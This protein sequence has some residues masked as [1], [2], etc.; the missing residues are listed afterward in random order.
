[1]N[2]DPAHVV[3]LTLDIV[4]EIHDKSI[5]RFGVSSGIRDLPLLESAVAAPQATFDGASPFEDLIE[6][7]AAYLFY[8]S[9]NHAF[10]DGNKRTSLAA[11][12]T[13]LRLNDIT[14]NSDS[15]E[16][17]KIA[18][19]LASSTLDRQETTTRLRTFLE[20]T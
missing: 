15:A 10:V 1:M 4:M 2:N 16:L 19:D 18:L 9:R 13:F 12:I 8:L 11:C 7:A 3:H 17:E 5:A 20:R 14:T 6:I